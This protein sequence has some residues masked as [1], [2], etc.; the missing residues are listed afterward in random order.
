MEKMMGLFNENEL[1]SI[2]DQVQSELKTEQTEAEKSTSCKRSIKVQ[3]YWGPSRPTFTM[4]KPATYVTFNSMT[5][6][7]TYGD[8]RN[9]L[10][11]KPVGADGS[12]YVY[13]IKLVPGTTYDLFVFYHNNGA[14]NFNGINFD[15]ITVAKGAYVRAE[16]PSRVNSDKV[17]YGNFY[18]GAE[19]A[20]PK[21]VFDTIAFTSDSSVA[22]RYIPNSA[23]LHNFINDDSSSST[24]RIFALN[25]EQLF[26]TGSP[27]GFNSM[28]GTLPGCNEYSGYITFQLVAD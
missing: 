7:P 3:H 25:A 17:Y 24:Q 13:D 10:H 15:G 16:F 26:R 2:A 8:E 14:K 21:C 9:F 4:E 28:N 18:I 19:N 20:N 27:I 5:N 1:K 12:K 22:L 11:I 6:N 23:K